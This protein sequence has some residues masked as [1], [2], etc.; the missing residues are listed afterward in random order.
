MVKLERIMLLLGQSLMKFL[1][2]EIEVDF[3]AIV[4]VQK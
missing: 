3:A 2:A 1:K 4:A